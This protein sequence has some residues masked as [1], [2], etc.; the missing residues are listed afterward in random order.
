MRSRLVT[1]AIR[2]FEV[3]VVA[4][5][6]LCGDQDLNRMETVGLAS[7]GRCDSQ[8]SNHA[9]RFRSS[10]PFLAE[11]RS[12]LVTLAVRVFEVLAV[13]RTSLCG[14]RDLNPGHE[15][16]RLRSYH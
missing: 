9:F 16:G 7:L 4:R 10:R 11:L 13:A 3:L 6:S 2:I 14:D 8:G 5:T 15:L 1:L 12:R